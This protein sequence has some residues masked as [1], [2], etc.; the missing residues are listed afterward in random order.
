MESVPLSSLV[1]AER[2]TAD[3]VRSIRRDQKRKGERNV[4]PDISPHVSGIRSHE[5]QAGNSVL[6]SREKTATVSRSVR[7]GLKASYKI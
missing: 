1:T 5:D 2:N 7:I 4:P 3:A 6:R